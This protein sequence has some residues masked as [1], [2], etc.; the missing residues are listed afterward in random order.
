VGE[1]MT[2][3]GYSLTTGAELWGPTEPDSNAWSYYGVQYVPAYGNFYT[4][5][6]GGH[7]K[8]FN[9]QTGEKLW[10]YQT[11]SAGYETPYGVWT[12]WTFTCG[13]VADGKFFVPEGHMYS[14]PLFHGAQQLAINTT[15]GELVWSVLAFDVTSAPAIADGYMMTLNAY[16]NQIYC[17]GKGQTAT[18][19]SAPTTEIPVG[20]RVLITGTVTEQSPDIA[21]SPCVSDASMS[22]WMEYM[23]MQQPK[24][25]NATGVPIKLTIY[26]PNGNSHD[27]ATTS[28]AMGTYGA[29]W[30]PPIEG[31]YQIIATF[32]GSESY[33]DSTATTYFLVGAAAAAPSPTIAP[34]TPTPPVTTATPTQSTSPSI[35]PSPPGAP[36]GAEFYVAIAAVVIIVVIAAIALALRRRK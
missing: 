36:I 17:F 21:G 31:L 6:F 23:Y 30:T 27:V 20:S 9:L 13:T 4:Y 35:A 7:V 28:D 25:T 16:D 15:T 12:L 33:F 19:V 2:W 1:T 24:P 18:T 32:Q 34:A 5:D 14:P 26:D 3:K 29:A 22:D 11:G 10:S 8:A